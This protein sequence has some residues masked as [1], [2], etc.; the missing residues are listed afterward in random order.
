MSHPLIYQKNTRFWLAQLSQ[1]LKRPA[2]LDDIPDHELERLSEM[3]F[4]WLYL[5]G[6]W[7]SGQKEARIAQAHAG[8]RQ[9]ARSKLGEANK[10]TL[11]ASFFAIS[12]YRVAQAWGGWQALKRLKIRLNKQGLRM[13]LDFIP[14]HTGISHPWV[15]AHPEFYINGSPADLEREPGSY[16]QLKTPSG[17]RILAHG[18]DP[19]F[20][21]W[22]DTLQL[23]YANP[24]LQEALK[25]ELLRLTRVC[26]GLRCDMA[27]LVIP[28]VFHRTWGVEIPPF[29]PSALMHVKEIRPDFVFLAEVYWDLE[30]QL[31]DQGFDFT[32]DK[33][34]YDRLV[35]RQA[36]PVHDQVLTEVDIIS[37]QAHFLENHD[38]KRAAEVFPPQCHQAAALIAF[39]L[40]GM[41]F[42]FD[43][44]L[45]GHSVQAPVQFCYPPPQTK[46][47][48]LGRFYRKLLVVLK[49]MDKFSGDWQLLDVS[50]A[51]PE[52]ASW[53]NLIAFAWFDDDIPSWI[54]VI[55]YAQSSSQGYVR[56]PFPQ[57]A[58][59]SFELNDR[60][61]S[62]SYLRDGSVLLENG[63]YVDRPAW[64]YHLFEL[65]EKGRGN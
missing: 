18:R 9:Q 13:M 48:Q 41:R 20:P 27:M 42:F 6:M 4:D 36:R 21:P 57:L 45:E 56:L 50:P 35:E 28:E 49:E 52:N 16:L 47:D 51:W 58:G 61:H 63:L 29:W 46:N 60:L 32:Y 65:E 22:T 55:N 5:L 10:K 17:S 12:G 64:G 26:D 33:R 44:Q 8:L 39:L 43:G 7:K 1:E 25:A 53:E 2:S 34:L 38:E 31:L 40:P 37:H 59:L 23:N 15:K 24:Q 11:C 30:H 14:N 62:E 3:G 19:Y 54:V